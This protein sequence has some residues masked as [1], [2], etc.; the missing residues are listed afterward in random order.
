VI[1]APYEPQNVKGGKGSAERVER[2][3]KMVSFSSG[4]P[5]T[6]NVLARA[7]YNPC[8]AGGAPAGANRARA[9]RSS[10]TS[11]VILDEV[12]IEAPYE[13]QNVKGGKGSAERVERVKKMVSLLCTESGRSRR[14]HPQSRAQSLDLHKRG[15]RQSQLFSILLLVLELREARERAWLGLVGARNAPLAH[16]SCEDFD[17]RFTSIRVPGIVTFSSIAGS[18]GE[19][20][21]N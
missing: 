17:T 6:G 5:R 21:K 4:T 19:R 13:P 18:R 7:S 9:R 1:E 12:V 11:I 10:A 14:G 15:A 20:E 16:L 8:A 2:V 3:K